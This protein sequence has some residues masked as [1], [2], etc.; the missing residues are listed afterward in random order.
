MIKNY[1]KLKNGLIKQ[2]NCKPFIYDSSYLEYYEKIK[3]ESIQI[4]YLR[5]GYLIGIINKIPNSLLDIGY[6][7]GDFLKISSQIISNCYGFDIANNPIPEHVKKIKSF[8]NKKFDVVC[9]FDSLEHF[10]DI[11]SIKKINTNYFIISVPECHY[12][13][14]NWFESWKHRKPNE[15]RWHFNKISLSNFMQEIG[16]EIISSCN[17]EDII[18]KPNDKNSNILTA[19]FKK[20]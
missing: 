15:H 1:K 18:R 6:G 5:L 19:V 3:L 11:Y 13:S 10:E 20:I 12:L 8:K 9:M 17:I 4:S 14:D 16:Y 2:I 7:N